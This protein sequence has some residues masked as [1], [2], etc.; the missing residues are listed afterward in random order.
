MLLAS[1]HRF[2]GSKRDRFCFGGSLPRVVEAFARHGLQI[3]ELDIQ[4]EEEMLDTARGPLLALKK[5][6]KHGS[7]SVGDVQRALVSTRN[8]LYI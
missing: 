3:D 2:F 6:N 4:G 8:D 5:I 1:L 7:R